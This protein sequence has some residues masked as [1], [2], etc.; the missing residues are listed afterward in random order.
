MAGC[1]SN[2]PEAEGAALG[3][4]YCTG[5]Q[6]VMSNPEKAMAFGL[7]W[8]TKSQSTAQKYASDPKKM[9]QY[10]KGYMNGTMNCAH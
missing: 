10:L 4:E 6:T 8:G 2:N 7:E 3:K 1:D 9:A 5:M